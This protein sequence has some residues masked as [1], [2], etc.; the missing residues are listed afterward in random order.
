M[1]TPED[2]RARLRA[3]HQTGCFV[4]PNPWDV[5]SARMLQAL[6]FPA[7]ASTSSGMAWA[8][9]RLDNEVP[10]DDA[11]AHLSVLTAAVDLPLNADFENG[12]AD[13][14]EDV[15]ANVRRAL[16]AGVAGLSIEALMWAHQRLIGRPEQRR[17]MLVISD[18]A[19]VDD[20]TLSVNS[21]HYL[22]RHLREVIA[23]I[24]GKSPVQLIAIGIGHD[25]TRY[26]KN[27]V[28]IVD[29]E[30]LAGA[31]VEQLADLFDEEP[32]RVTRKSAGLLAPPPNTQ[33]PQ[34]PVRRSTFKEVRKVSA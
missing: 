14:P 29:V 4:I 23:E 2:L 8:S 9:G 1:P 18:G 32:R 26:Y 13:A 28:T 22:E 19:P 21:G 12:Y 7:L 15:A 5:G 31:M 34:G 25:V 33:G 20:S 10:L 6:G 27:A 30:Q 17:I 24:E 3:L 11:L 16:G